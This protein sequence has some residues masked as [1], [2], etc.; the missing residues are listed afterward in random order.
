MRRFR[1]ILAADLLFQN[2]YG[3]HL[4]YTFFSL[5]YIGVIY[6]IPDNWRSDTSSLVIFS[7]PAMLGL[8]FIGAIVLFEKSERVLDSIAV[9]PVKTGEYVLSKGISLAL[10]S[11]ISGLLIA[12]VGGEKPHD[13][14]QFIL[15]ILL[16]SSLFTFMGLICS[17]RISTLNQFIVIIIPIQLIV[18]G[19]VIVY[20]FWNSN[21]LWLIHPGVSIFEL[22]SG[23]HGHTI[24]ADISLMVWFVSTF[25]IAKKEFEKT[26]K[27]LGGVR[28]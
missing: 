10:I 4:L 5:I 17:T 6:F 14:V 15:G 19:P 8:I 16:G 9:S 7:D 24:L 23:K 20:S 12:Y 22:I 26:M 21:P 2:R 13:L 25:L 1:K 28:L 11:T 18:V 27:A 3:F